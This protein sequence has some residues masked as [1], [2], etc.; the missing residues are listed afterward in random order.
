MPSAPPSP[1]AADSG[2]VQ[3]GARRAAPPRLPRA[4]AARPQRC[5]ATCRAT[6][7]M[8]ERLTLKKWR[9]MGRMKVQAVKIVEGYGASSTTSSATRYW[10]YSA[11]RPPTRT[12]VRAARAAL[13]LHEMTRAMSR[14][15]N[16]A[17]AGR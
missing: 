13:A 5:S 15:W 12:T 8:N 7:A 3:P 4:T 16:P 2:P 14:R 10:P 17:W 11:Y 9:I 6:P 1:T